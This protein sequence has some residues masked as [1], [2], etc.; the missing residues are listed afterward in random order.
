MNKLIF[1]AGAFFVF[2]VLSGYWLSHSGRPLNGLILTI[3]K[4][5]SLAAVIYL[6]INIVRLHQ[7]APLAPLAIA[8]SALALLFFLALI[9]TGGLLSVA[10]PMPSFVHTIHQVGPYLTVL[11]TA[12]A[13][14]LALFPRP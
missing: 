9:A 10:K 11:S 3:H 8:L 6:G 2:T 12:A 7:A 13:L 5:I 14:Y 4:L 1:I